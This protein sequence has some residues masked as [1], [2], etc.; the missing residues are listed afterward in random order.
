[1][2]DTTSPRFKIGEMLNMEDLIVIETKDQHQH[3]PIH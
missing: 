1:L 2:D 3:S